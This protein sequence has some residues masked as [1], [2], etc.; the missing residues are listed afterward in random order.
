MRIVTTELQSII[1][2][3]VPI[4]EMVCYGNFLFKEIFKEF[5]ADELI[6]TLVE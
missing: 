3:T 5:A 6:I 4:L 1:H 2:A